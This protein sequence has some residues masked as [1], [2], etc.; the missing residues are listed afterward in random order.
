MSVVEAT[1]ETVCV[2]NTAAGTIRTGE[3]FR[4]AKDKIAANDLGFDATVPRT[5]M[6]Q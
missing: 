5:M 2:T 1:R 6:G 4:L 3:L